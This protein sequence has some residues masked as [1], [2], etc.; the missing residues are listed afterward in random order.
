MTFQ[1]KSLISCVW[2]V[3]H[4]A[5]DETRPG[6]A[7]AHRLSPSHRPEK[8]LKRFLRRFLGGARVHNRS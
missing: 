4:P 6:S 8:R 7:V 3:V 1:G 2:G 5:A